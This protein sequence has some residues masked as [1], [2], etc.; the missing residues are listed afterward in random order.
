MNEPLQLVLSKLEDAKPTGK[1]KWK[2]LYPAHPDRRPSLS[3]SSVPDGTVLLKCHAGCNLAAVVGALGLKMRDLFPRTDTDGNRSRPQ[4]KRDSVGTIGKPG[5]TYKTA[6]LAVAALEKRHGHRSADWTYHDADGTPVGLIVRWDL[7]EGRKDI[8]PVARFPEGWRAEGMPAPRPLYKLPELLGTQGLV[9]VVEGERAAEAGK[10]VGLLTTTSPHGAHAATAADWTPL[11]GRSVLL[12]PDADK[13]GE[14]YAADVARVLGGLKPAAKVKIVRLPD[15]PDGGDLVEYVAARRAAGLDGAEIR[16]EIE[17]LA[18]A[19]EEEQPVGL[20][21]AIEPYRPF[22]VELIPEPM[23][24]FIRAAATAIGCD[25]AFVAMPTLAALAS[26]IG[27]TRRIQLKRDWQE[28]CILWTVIVAES[29]AKKSPPMDAALRPLYKRQ[30]EAFKRFAL[31]MQEYKKQVKEYK[32]ALAKWEKN[33][34]DAAV[35]EEP[36]VPVFDRCWCDDTT[37]EAVLCLLAQRWRGMLMKRDELSAWFGSF[38]K[39]SKGRGGGDAP[40]WLEMFGGRPIVNDRKTSGMLYVPRAALSVTGGIQ[41]GILK[42]SLSQDYRENGLLARLLPAMPPPKPRAWSEAS[43]D[44]RLADAVD[45]VYDRLFALEPGLKDDG[46]PVPVDLPLTPEG[47]QAWVRF[48]NEH[49]TEQAELT[50]DLSAAWS[51]LEGYAARLALVVHLVRWAAGDPTLATAEAVDAE[52]IAA[53][54]GLSRWFGAECRRIYAVLDESS[55]QQE[56]RQLVELLQRKGGVA[57]P[58]DLQRWRDR[59]YPTAAEAE[60]ALGRLV[61]VG[62]GTWQTDDHDGGRGRPALQFL[63]HTDS[64]ANRPEAQEKSNCVSVSTKDDSE[65]EWG[66]V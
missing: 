20:A 61:K 25:P 62:L 2:A 21:H 12:L 53:G 45:V 28:P 58:R 13:A 24:G 59:Q 23:Q 8:R 48:Y 16:A 18:A 43:I 41:P 49:A 19:V 1:G 64:D 63:L 11:A 15:M 4:K 50:G 5:T 7:R 66:D 6:S 27:N 30:H 35:P 52:S 29:G 38:D 14:Q 39:Y 34:G 37:V 46:D 42:R 55:E 9:V 31:E 44:P 32:R 47:K 56:L 10:D 65:A 3:I 33:K 57:T 60:E 36:T 26:S 22:P 17:Q 40:K 51:K 54:V